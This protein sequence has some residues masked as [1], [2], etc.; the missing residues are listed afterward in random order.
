MPQ[1][2]NNVAVIY[3]YEGEKA[4]EAGNVEEAESFYD[5]AAEYWKQAIRIAPNNYLEAQNWLKTTGRSEMDV[6][7]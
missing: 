6:F 7:F 2:L 5:K 3:H 1:A 4:K